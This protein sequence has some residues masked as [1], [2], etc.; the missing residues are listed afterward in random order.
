MY[1]IGSI[2]DG[3][4]VVRICW[5]NSDCECHWVVVAYDSDDR[6]RMMAIMVVVNILSC[7]TI[8]NVKVII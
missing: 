2:G 6:V 7:T 8:F 4:V 3:M 5:H 1:G